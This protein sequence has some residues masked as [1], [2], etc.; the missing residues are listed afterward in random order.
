[1]EKKT[2]SKRKRRIHR[3]Q[4]LK[5]RRSLTYGLG[6]SG[7]QGSYTPLVLGLLNTLQHDHYFIFLCKKT[8]GVLRN[9]KSARKKKHRA[10]VLGEFDVVLNAGG[11]EPL[12]QPGQLLGGPTRPLLLSLRA[13]LRVVQHL[14]LHPAKNTQ[15]S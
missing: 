14:C 11:G 8:Q 9:K 1:M 13:L 3:V 10:R 4:D 5:K 12:V 6:L 2:G 15:T 7:L